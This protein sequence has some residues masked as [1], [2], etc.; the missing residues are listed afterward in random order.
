MLMRLLKR[1]PT[2]HGART[3]ATARHPRAVFEAAYYVNLLLL[4]FDGLVDSLCFLALFWQPQ[5]FVFIILQTLSQTQV[6]PLDT[7]AKG[8]QNALRNLEFLGTHASLQCLAARHR[9][10]I[11]E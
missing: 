6:S 2:A 11:L 1:S 5:P 7:Y 3:P 9:H 10:R 8:W 4:C